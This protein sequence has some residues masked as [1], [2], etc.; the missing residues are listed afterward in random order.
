MRV[1]IGLLLFVLPT[2]AIGIAGPKVAHDVP[3]NP[4]L[5]D[6]FRLMYELRFDD[7]R[8]RL[9]DCARANAQDP[10]CVAAEAASFLF[11]RFNQI[12]VLT[13][14]FFLNDN[15]LLGGITGV[16][17]QKRDA[18]FLE[19]NQRARKMAETRLNFDPQDSN[20]LLTLVLTNGMQGNYEA[21][22]AKHQIDSLRYTKRAEGEARTLLRVTPD[23]GDAYVA[24]G[25]ANYIIGCLPAY[26]RFVLWF[27]GIQG[28][29][30]AGMQQLQVAATRGM[31][32]QPLAKTMLALA[33]EREHQP[34]RARILFGDLNREFPANPIFAREL[35]LLQ[36]R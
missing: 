27:G 6:S 3:V 29:R 32:L 7:S 36:S 21:L 10:L 4:L 2:I 20:A 15:L 34:D 14:A 18:A 1:L 23:N 25:A 17:D 26:K 8:A 30:L 28:D 35:L 13:S 9:G 19:A 5:M 24:I 33:A 22:I 12:G 31:Y 11:E 16:P